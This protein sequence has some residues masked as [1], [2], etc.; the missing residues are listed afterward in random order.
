MYAFSIVIV[1]LKFYKYIIPCIAS[2]ILVFVSVYLVI[3]SIA[4]ILHYSITQFLQT[5]N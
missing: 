3:I 4:I 5:I 1:F 2:A